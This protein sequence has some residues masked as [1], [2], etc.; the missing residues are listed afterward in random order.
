MTAAFATPPA[1]P[2]P[3]QALVEGMLA[4]IASEL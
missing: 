2:A 1:A 4:T 3:P